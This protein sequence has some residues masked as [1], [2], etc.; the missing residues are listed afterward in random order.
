MEGIDSSI[1]AVAANT[2]GAQLL[3]ATSSGTLGL[4]DIAQR[5]YSTIMR[6][7]TK[8]RLCLLVHYS[9]CSRPALRR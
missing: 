2:N 6:G 7:H 8:V 9:H 3:A 1:I 4:L 5:K